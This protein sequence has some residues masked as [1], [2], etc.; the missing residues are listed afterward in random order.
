MPPWQQGEGDWTVCDQLQQHAG[1]QSGG[2]SSVCS[3]S[4]YERHVPLQVT[5]YKDAHCNGVP[6]IPLANGTLY[7]PGNCWIDVYNAICNAKHFIYACG[8]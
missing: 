2:L 8:M 1:C 7:K 4:I 3:Q 5:M 6:D